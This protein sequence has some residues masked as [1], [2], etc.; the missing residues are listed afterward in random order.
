M[1]SVLEGL[2]PRQERTTMAETVYLDIKQ[3][4]L[5]GL[6]PPGEKVTLRG[7]AQALGT[8]P[9]PVRDA[10][11]RLVTEG[12]FE[13]MPNRGFRVFKPKLAEFREI[14]KLRCCL[15]GFAAEEAV[16]HL[17]DKEIKQIKAHARKFQRLANRRKVDTFAVVQANRELHFTLYE[18]SAMPR[19]VSMIENVWTQIGSLFSL[20]MNIERRGVAEW[21]SFQHHERLIAAL[22]A[23][24]GE[25]ARDAVVNDILDASAHIEAVANLKN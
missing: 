17:T 7:L 6:I 16:V 3:L 18:A 24:D 2:L 8:S 4:L 15:E 10:V 12:A 14:V 11:A 25:G 13:A 5:A 9:M 22:I 20:S 1:N 19:L 23:R 21:E